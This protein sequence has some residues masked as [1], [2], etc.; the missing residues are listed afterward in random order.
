MNE[1]TLTFH[2]LMSPKKLSSYLLDD[3]RRFIVE[4]IVAPVRFNEPGF[5]FGKC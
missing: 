3:L 4:E 5:N 1:K 2:G